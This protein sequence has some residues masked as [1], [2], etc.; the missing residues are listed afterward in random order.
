MTLD[1]LER[2]KLVVDFR[3]LRAMWTVENKVRVGKDKLILFQ[4]V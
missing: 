1:T 4:A 3:L 2:L